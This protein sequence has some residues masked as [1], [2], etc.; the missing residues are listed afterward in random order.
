MKIM[1]EMHTE[2]LSYNIALKM[3]ALLHRCLVVD[4]SVRN[5]I[6]ISDSKIITPFNHDVQRSVSQGQHNHAAFLGC[7]YNGKV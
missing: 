7:E 4:A 1:N 5:S 6:D 2:L 3:M